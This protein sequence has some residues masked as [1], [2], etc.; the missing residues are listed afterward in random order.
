MFLTRTPRVFVILL[1]YQNPADTLRC[2]ASLRRSIKRDVHPVVVDNGSGNGDVDRLL[3]EGGPALSVLSNEVNLG[4]AAGNNVGI[5]HALERDA[6][7]VWILNPDTEVEPDTLQAMMTTMALRPDAGFVGSL[8]LFG[9][10]D[11]P[12]IQFAG[13]RIDWDAGVV[14]ESIDRGKPLGATARRDPYVV[15]YVAGTSMLVRRRVFDEIGLLPE[16][17]FLYF[18]ETDFQVTAAKRG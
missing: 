9:D 14:V 5:R 13:G 2:L 11:P 10:T 16:H 7:F 17:Y 15:D 12:V 3:A 18:E 4:Y 8:N 6:D 1:N